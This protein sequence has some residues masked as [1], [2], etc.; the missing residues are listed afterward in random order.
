MTVYV[1]LR[2]HHDPDSAIL[3]TFSSEEKA[4]DAISK[5]KRPEQK[6][7]IISY[8]IEKRDIDIIREDAPAIVEIRMQEDKVITEIKIVRCDP[9]SI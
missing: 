1:V 2:E 3:G 6:K 7:D 4:R 5:D 9:S 8:R